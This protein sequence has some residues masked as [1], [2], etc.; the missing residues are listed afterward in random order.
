MHVAGQLTQQLQLSALQQCWRKFNFLAVNGGRGT[1]RPAALD[2]VR[3]RD[4]L[5]ED[6]RG[7]NQSLCVK[8]PVMRVMRFP[9]VGFST[10]PIQSP[11]LSSYASVCTI[12]YAVL[13]ARHCMHLSLGE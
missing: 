7:A 5:Q 12:A 1:R 4:E 10:K 9:F 11:F 2:V 13:A 8:C 6:L 3:A